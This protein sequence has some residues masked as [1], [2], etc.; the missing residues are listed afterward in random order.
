MKY[1]CQFILGRKIL[2]RVVCIPGISKKI[3]PAGLR[4]KK[5]TVGWH[6]STVHKFGDDL[7]V[8]LLKSP[9]LLRF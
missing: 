1:L 3:Q 6:E 4:R 8:G 7:L 2:L 5:T 9:Q